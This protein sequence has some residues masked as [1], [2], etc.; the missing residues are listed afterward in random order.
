MRLAQRGQ[1]QDRRPEAIGAARTR[2]L[3]QPVRQQFAEQP[4][5]GGLVHAGRAREVTEPDFGS[6]AREVIQ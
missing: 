2:L 6:G 5:D 4:I 3:D 1:P